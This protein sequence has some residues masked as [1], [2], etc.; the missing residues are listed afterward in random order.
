MANFDDEL[1]MDAEE[2]QRE[3]AFI[4]KQLPAELKDKFQDDE[5]LF[6]METIVDYYFTSG[7]LDAEP[8][9]DGYV[10]IDMQQIAEHVCLKAAEEG[11]GPYDADEI[12]FI[13]QADMDFQEGNV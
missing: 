11:H 7:I 8:D 13:V 12:Y 3:M 9:K 10:D 5:L 6:I 4:R 1:R 2:N